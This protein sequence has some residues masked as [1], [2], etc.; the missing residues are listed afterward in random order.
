MTITLNYY[1]IVNEFFYTIAVIEL[2][3]WWWVT[4]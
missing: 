2:H 4:K 1:I 3:L